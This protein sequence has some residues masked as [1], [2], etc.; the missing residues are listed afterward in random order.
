VQEHLAFLDEAGER[1][2]MLEQAITE[3]QKRAVGREKN[4]LGSTNSLGLTLLPQG[5][6][7]AVR[8]LSPTAREQLGHQSPP[9]LILVIEIRK[10]LPVGQRQLV[11]IAKA[12]GIDGNYSSS[13]SG[14][15]RQCEL[16][17][18]LL[19]SDCPCSRACK[20]FVRR[21][22]LHDKRARDRL[23]DTLTRKRGS[24]PSK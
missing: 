1:V 7:R 8:R 2:L 13:T 24:V 14:V 12:H 10:R 16:A 22:V 21:R 3:L 11:E 9:R 6:A 15:V 5:I 20:D 18:Q 23:S 17:R 19:E 4:A